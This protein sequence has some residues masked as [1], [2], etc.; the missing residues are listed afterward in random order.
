MYKFRTMYQDAPE[1]R[2]GLGAQNEATGFLFKMEKDPRET[3]IGRFL[4]GTGLDELPQLINVL[5]G[6]MSLIGPRPLPVGD[7]DFDQLK[8]NQEL[9]N[10][11]QRRSSLRP[12]MT[13]WWQIHPQAKHSFQEM[14]KLDLGYVDNYSIFFDLKIIYLTFKYTLNNIWSRIGPGKRQ[15]AGQATTKE[16]A[17]K[18]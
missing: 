8:K 7:V 13:G 16:Q 6:E 17:K 11:W 4:R 1:K 2:N 12:G 10:R 15:A 3:R 9:S 14:L 18:I 5:K